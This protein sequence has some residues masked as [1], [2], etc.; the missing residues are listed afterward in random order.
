M[1]TA[2]GPALRILRNRGADG[3]EDVSGALGLDKID[4]GGLKG[5]RS[6]L[7]LDGNHDG[8]ADLLIARQ[9]GPPLVLTNVGGNRHHSIRLDLTGLADNKSG[10]GT[11]VEVFSEGNWQ[12]FEVAGASGYMSQGTTEILAGI[13]DSEHADVVRLLWPTGV[14]QDELDMAS[15]KPAALTELDRRGSSC[16]VLFAWDGTKYV[17]VSDV[18]GAGVVGHW[19]SPVA[20][21]KSDE[22]EWTR[23]DGASL[24][25]RNGNLS[26]RFGEPM[27]EINYIDSLCLRQNHRRLKPGASTRRCLGRC[28]PQCSARAHRPRSPVSP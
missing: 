14:P 13:G 3:F 27:E 28:G 15:S 22:D 17:F 5:A 11:K 16:P 6:V 2:N 20:Y 24:K 21:N 19:I 18:I 26:V 25:A 1:E 8:A 10:I 7:A 23:I 9:E 4:A 12:K